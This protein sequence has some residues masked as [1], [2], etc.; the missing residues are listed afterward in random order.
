MVLGS[1]EDQATD[2]AEPVDPNTEG[3]IA[4]SGGGE[5]GLCCGKGGRDVSSYVVLAFE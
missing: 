2:A 4:D 3:G 5:G 1:A